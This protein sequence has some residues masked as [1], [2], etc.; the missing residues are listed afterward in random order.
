MRPASAMPPRRAGRS[1]SRGRFL[2]FTLAAIVL[3]VALSLR[4]TSNFY[5]NFLWF[6]SL[7]QRAVW[8]GVLRAELGLFFAFTGFFFLLLLLNLTIADRL[9]PVRR[10]AGP[11]EELL[12]RFHEFVSG[13]E[14]L[15][16]VA[17]AGLFSLIAGS[18][19]SDQWNEWVLFSNRVDFGTVDPLF[20]LDIGFYVFQLP[21]LTFVVNW[22]FAAFVFVLFLTIMAH[23]INGG[24]RLQTPG[25][26]ATPQVT[27][28]LSVILAILAAI[29]AAD[30]YLQRYELTVSTRGVVD[31]ATYTDI[32]AQLPAIKLL[33]LISLF[34]VV[35]LLANIWWRGWTLPALAVGL[36]AFVAIVMGG[37]NPAVVQRFQVDPN[38]STREAEYTTLNIEATRDAL[39]LDVDR[40]GFQYDED[41]E[42][43]DDILRDNADIL[44]DIRLI[45]PLIVGPAFQSFEG[46]RGFYKFPNV[47]DTDRYEIDGELTPVVIGARELDLTAQNQWEN[48]HVRFTHGF[49]L[50]IAQGDTVE[51]SGRPDFLRVNDSSRPDPRLDLG[52][53]QPQLYYSENLDG[54]SVVG[55][56]RAEIDF[57]E[58]SE[59]EVT[60]RYEGTGGVPIDSF[61]RK[62]AFSI[63]FGQIDPLISEF[64][65]DE[66]KVLFNRDIVDRAKKLAPFLQFD[67]DP[68]PVVL[69]GR[70]HYVIDAYTTS[71]RY[72]Y[73]QRADTDRVSARSGLR[74]RNN[75][76]RGSVKAVVD[77]YNG[78][79]D[80]YR[81]PNV[82]DPIIEAYS[83]AFPDLIQP[84]ES[85]PAD[86][87][88][89]LRYPQDLFT[90]QSNMWGRY[91]LSS[92]QPDAFLSESAGWIVAADP[93]RSPT[94]DST[95]ITSTLAG[96][97]TS[98]R[99]VSPY[100]AVMT[101]P[102]E[103]EEIFGIVRTFVPKPQP[104]S[105]RPQQSELTAMLVADSNPE[106][107][108]RLI[109]YRMS[110]LNVPGP[111][112]VAIDI[113]SDSQISEINTLLNAN[114]SNVEYGD[115]QLV[116]LGESILYVRPLYVKAEGENAVP[117]LRNV[118]VSMG[119][120]V[121]IAPT[122][123]EAIDNLFGTT[124]GGAVVE[125]QPGTPAA[126]IGEPDD[127]FAQPD[128][129][130]DELL[131]LLEELFAE[132]TQRAESALERSERIAEQIVERSEELGVEPPDEYLPSTTTTTAPPADTEESPPTTEPEP[133]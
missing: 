43:T 88:N 63:R 91:Q 86:M 39:G 15:V 126:D 109:E 128:P 22:L 113:S 130:R 96:D 62:L 49:G 56:T 32:N 105:G 108:G 46:D 67:S 18:G 118:V 8:W 98:V 119:G 115:F 7:D 31:G 120:E 37:I 42:L 122:L 6:E 81:T 24:L 100:Y 9:A 33:M 53:D 64:I 71:D 45:D 101:L 36:W 104:N 102:G 116:L 99:R 50:G 44:D 34:A 106:S 97:V 114:G 29:K 89:H 35:L 12:E 20:N 21:F 30:Y 131:A 132:E 1:A 11:E 52:L 127:S 48:E 76:I 14:R 78:T 2:L 4:G 26:R 107:Y 55:T 85:M 92:E 129:D 25:S 10:P 58:T 28:H 65:T 17:L 93:G 66:S 51:D 123:G 90:I 103:D 3:I 79:V 87:V 121:A 23:Y 47:L 40:R 84:F 5:T 83:A 72:P 59:E 68:Y 13:R 61:F 133:A 41:F 70:V 57:S 27:A 75:Y 82:E 54:Y 111:T 16:R 125:R 124:V 74:G 77:T 110:N 95:E 94:V 38:Q 80:Y 19:V 117:E 69:E 112:N 73:A 60:T